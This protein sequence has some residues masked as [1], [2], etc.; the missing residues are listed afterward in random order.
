MLTSSSLEA[1]ARKLRDG[2]VRY[3]G[4]AVTLGAEEDQA[5][6]FLRDAWRSLKDGD[7]GAE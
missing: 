1:Q 2:A 7:G 4:L 3:A 6:D 5:V